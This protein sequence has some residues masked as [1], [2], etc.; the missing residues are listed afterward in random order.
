[1]RNSIYAVRAD[2]EDGRAD[3]RVRFIERVRV[4]HIMMADERAD[5]FLI[6]PPG[7]RLYYTDKFFTP[8][9]IPGIAIPCSIFKPCRYVSKGKKV[10]D[11]YRLAFVA[12]EGQELR[13][14]VQ[15]TA[16]DFASFICSLICEPF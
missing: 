10:E 2:L 3:I 14:S 11:F 15:R 16:G 13:F 8:L 12:D 1:M 6:T 9:T 4:V 5:S 7:I